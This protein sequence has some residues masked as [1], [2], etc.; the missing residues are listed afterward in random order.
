MML[1]LGLMLALRPAWLN[2]IGVTL[3]LIGFAVL[4]TYV[5]SRIWPNDQAA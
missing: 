5:C 1:G 4:S 2:H 3:L